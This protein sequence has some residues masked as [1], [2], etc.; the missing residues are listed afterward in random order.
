DG[1]ACSINYFGIRWNRYGTSSSNGFNLVA[2]Y[3]NYTIFDDLIALHGDN[4]CIRKRFTS[5]RLVEGHFQTD[6]EPDAVGSHRFG[7]RR[8]KVGK[9]LINIG[10]KILIAEG[11]VQFAS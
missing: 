6:L 10:R 3:D 1:L 11:P 9:S 7:T 4:T 8:I 2:I 5:S